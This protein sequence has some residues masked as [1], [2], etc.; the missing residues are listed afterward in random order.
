MEQIEEML[1][2]PSFMSCISEFLNSKKAPDSES[3]AS[4]STVVLSLTV[5]AATQTSPSVALLTTSPSAS[6]PSSAAAQTPPPPTLS[7]YTRVKE[8]EIIPLDEQAFC[9]HRDGRIRGT[10]ELSRGSASKK[11]ENR[12]VLAIA[13]LINNP[14]LSDKQK[15]YALRKASTH[16]LCRRIFHSAGLIDGE[17]YEAMK[18]F[19][20]QIKKLVQEAT[21]TDDRRG[22]ASDDKRALVNTVLLTTAS[23]PSTENEPNEFTITPSSASAPPSQRVL[24]I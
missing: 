9:Y 10:G 17:R 13:H 14:K 24:L 22:R 20:S 8:N 3:A 4:T 16:H 11:A 12:A 15:V 19:F 6:V 5:S 18:H 7:K 1:Q 23:T 2:D 21:A